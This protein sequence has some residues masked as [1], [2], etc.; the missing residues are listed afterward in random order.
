MIN[1]DVDQDIRA[2]HLAAAKAL[3]AQR[4]EI[5]MDENQASAYFHPT[6]SVEDRRIMKC[7]VVRLG[8]ANWLYPEFR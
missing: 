8:L 7:Y 6:M 1:D 3:N 2:R 4:D 5:V